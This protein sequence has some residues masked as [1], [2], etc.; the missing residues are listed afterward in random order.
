M[1][2]NI[3]VETIDKAYDTIKDVVKKTP[4]QKLHRFSKKYGSNIYLKREDLQE[5]RSYKIRGAFNLMSN[6]YSKTSKFVCASA[7]NH[8]QGVAFTASYLKKKSIIFMPKTT[9]IQKISRV[10]YFGGTYVEIKLDG[11]N[12]EECSNIAQDFSRKHK[13]FYVPPFNNYTII[14]GQ[15]TIGKEILSQVK[16]ID[17][18][19]CPIG[20]GGLISGVGTY[21]KTI[22]P[23]VKLIG[24]EPEGA[25]SMYESIKNNKIINLTQL[26]NFADRVAV[27]KVG[28]ITFKISKKIIDKIV[29]VPEGIIASTMIDIYQNEGIV[30]EPAGALS[31]SALDSI[32]DEI[33]GKNVVCILSGGNNDILR[34]PEIMEKSLVYQGLKHYFMIEFYQKP[35]ELK[36]FITKCLGKNDDIV[37]FEYIKKVSKEQGFALVGIEIASKNDIIP[38]IEKM[39]KNNIKYTK[40]EKNTLLYETL[41]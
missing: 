1:D 3:N 6:Q 37:R 10:N 31:L 38:L 4:T 12:F 18:V 20:G 25:S 2:E 13:Y 16:D 22:K 34:Y 33:K 41:I 19:I 15:G 9:P 36:N 32:K 35:G 23:S 30:S 40:I 24:I 29:I 39:N 28:D 27:S 21:I 8:A 11:N 17:Y 7:G 26:D 14:S 5:I